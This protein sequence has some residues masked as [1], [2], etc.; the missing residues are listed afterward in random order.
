MRRLIGRRAS[1]HEPVIN[2][3][4]HHNPAAD[5]NE[6]GKQSRAYPGYKAK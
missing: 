1:T 5:P 6:T 3:R 4:H 2:D